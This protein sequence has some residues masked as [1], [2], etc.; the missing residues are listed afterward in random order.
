M[1][2]ERRLTH[3]KMVARSF[4]S[5]D[6]SSGRRIFGAGQNSKKDELAST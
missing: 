2:A 3:V 1:S 5:E 6:G 4:A